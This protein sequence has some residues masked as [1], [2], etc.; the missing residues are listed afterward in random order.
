[1][2]DAASALT[3]LHAKAALAKAE[4]GQEHMAAYFKTDFSKIGNP[5]YEPYGSLLKE[6]LISGVIL[7]EP[8]AVR[9]KATLNYT[10]ELTG[11]NVDNAGSGYQS[12][13]LEVI[14][15]GNAAGGSIVLK[16]KG[17]FAGI[18]ITNPGRGYQLEPVV[19]LTGDLADIC[20]PKCTM[21]GSTDSR[22]ATGEERDIT[23]VKE[24]QL[25]PGTKSSYIM[26]LLALIMAQMHII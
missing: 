24:I 23:K 18:E 8:T 20:H 19:T 26:L 14:G 3:A 16:D 7:N 5:Q 12:A 11:F 13:A 10:S 25:N 4:M 6:E 1:M 22:F 9:A 15:S 17:A 21:T 2:V